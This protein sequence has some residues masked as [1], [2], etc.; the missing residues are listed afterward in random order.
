MMRVAVIA[1]ENVDLGNGKRCSSAD[2]YLG[3]HMLGRASLSPSAA[4][5]FA[6]HTAVSTDA[7]AAGVGYTVIENGQARTVNIT[8]SETA[9]ADGANALDGD[10]RYVSHPLNNAFLV[11]NLRYVDERVTKAQPLPGCFKPRGA[12][13]VTGRMLVPL[14]LCM[15]LLKR[16]PR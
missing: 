7:I 15:A 2:A 12:E 10:A 11:R 14:H 16:Q 9:R 13:G 6:S 5:T 1:P 3:R 4:P 8:K